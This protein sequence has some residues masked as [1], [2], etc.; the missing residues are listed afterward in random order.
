MTQ[1][2]NQLAVITPFEEMEKASKY[3]AESGLFGITKPAQA[4]CLFMICQADGVNYIEALRRYHLVDNKPAMRADYMQGK[5]ISSGGAIIFHA[6]T[7]DVCAATLFAD[8]SK[9]DD[10]ARER[11]VARFEKLWDLDVEEDASKRTALI[12]EI[13]KLSREGEE[14]IIRTFEDAQAKGLTTSWKK[15]DKGEYKEKEKTNW[16]QSPRQMLTARVITE[17]VRLIA[18]GLIAGVYT[19]DEVEDII[20]SEKR[21]REE[22]VQTALKAPDPRD[23]EAIQR[24]IDQYVEDAKTAKPTEKSRLLGLASELRVKLA[25]LDDEIPGIAR[26]TPV[27]DELPTT[28]E[29]ELHLAGESDPVQI[30]WREYALQYCKSKTLLGKKLGSFTPEEIGVIAIKTARGLDSSN[31]R[32]RAEANY[33][34]EADQELNHSKEGK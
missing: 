26:P 30:P 18:P 3:A 29:P 8:K 28:A 15:D 6:R 7:D 20:N 31:L 23:R 5:F 2:N 32:I 14:T 9:L 34:K 33:I 27:A 24:M 21:E 16:K 4:M 12:G 13:A 10:K 1:E 11:A 17:G 19:P 25:D 22:F